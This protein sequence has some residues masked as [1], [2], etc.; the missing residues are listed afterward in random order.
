M[1][2]FLAERSA[3]AD[4]YKAYTD[5]IK[6]IN[7]IPE[8]MNFEML[9]DKSRLTR[10]IKPGIDLLPMDA[11]FIDLGCGTGLIGFYA[12]EK[13]A[14]FVYFVERDPQMF[15]ILS[16]VLPK[17][18][19]PNKYK[20]IHK[21]IQDLTLDDFDRGIPEVATSEFYGPLLFDEGYVSYSAHIKSLFPKCV[22][23]P[24]TFV[25]EVKI[26][27]VDFGRFPWPQHE[28]DVLEHFKIMYAEKGYNANT[29][30]I[31]NPELLNPILVGT[32]DFNANKQTFDNLVEINIPANKEKM[33]HID[34]SV[35]HRSLVHNWKYVGW[36]IPRSEVEQKF[37]FH[38][39]PDNYQ[40]VLK[41]G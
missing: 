17:R 26:C 7:S 41:M 21:D 8:G 12:L 28:P 39:D 4:S 25:A 10:I 19:D 33:I 32:V 18:L 1:T 34:Y 16:K 29:I 6:D 37:L 35:K 5:N 3:I 11:T 30:N 9:E 24:E 15:Y 36:Y 27:D 40:P 13:G 20:L 14:K 38:I 22:F 2:Y 23:I 31:H